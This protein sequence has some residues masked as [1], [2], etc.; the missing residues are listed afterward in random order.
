MYNI[1]VTSI[2]TLRGG[3]WNNGASAGTFALNL[4]NARSNV[5]DNVGFRAALPITIATQTRRFK[6]ILLSIFDKGDASRRYMRLRFA[7]NGT[8]N[9]PR[10]L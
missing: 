9:Q 7:Y 10:R 2:C 4:N 8:N 1:G 5:N 3:N 6:E